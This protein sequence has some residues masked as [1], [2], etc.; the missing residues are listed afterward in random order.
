MGPETNTY[1]GD[2]YQ[3][4]ACARNNADALSANKTTENAPNGGSL[5]EPGTWGK[6]SPFRQHGLVHSPT[7]SHAQ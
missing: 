1:P 6:D 5:A 2:H 3:T 7:L 4:L